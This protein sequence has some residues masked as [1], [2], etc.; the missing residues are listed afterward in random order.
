MTGQAADTNVEAEMTARGYDGAADRYNR[1]RSQAAMIALCQPGGITMSSTPLL[2]A[3]FLQSGH[4]SQSE[5]ATLGSGQ[6]AGM[7]TG[8]LLSS[9]LIARFDRRL[10]ALA[11]IAL[12]IVGHLVSI[13]AVESGYFATLAVRA[14]AGLGEGVLTG[15]GIASLA[16]L[17]SPDRAFGLTV[18]GNLLG[19]ALMFAAMPALMALGGYKAVLLTIV[20]YTLVFGTA[21]FFLPPRGL[22][23]PK[24]A[25]AAPVDVRALLRGC[26]GLA[27]ML[28]L[29]CGV[30]TIWP[31]TPLIGTSYG[32][33]GSSI[34]AAL[35]AAG[36]GGLV[37][38]LFASWLGLR[39]GR[40][41]PILTGGA[42]MILTVFL[43]LN[44]LGPAFFTAEV[45]LFM[46][47][48]IFSVPFYM[49]AFA[50]MDVSGRLAVLSTAMQSLG[51]SA[52]QALGAWIIGAALG[53]VVAA[54]LAMVLFAAA[55]I[56][57]TVLIRAHR[58]S[59][60]AEEPSA[61][62]QAA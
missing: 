26:L 17:R 44:P 31:L 11:A 60:A 49:A 27:V 12:A 36:I 37:A 57:M 28:L 54:W 19:S 2:L 24:P 52:G 3:A 40:V 55:A 25:S 7:T 46:V 33:S 23:V 38:A 16:G 22:A 1:P 42:G 20:G 30:G 29:F 8:Y 58:R 6:L 59:K 48:W 56:L 62:L 32:I 9:L 51:M 47:F 35:S 4:F 15:V 53:H 41:A 39:F 18:S 14:F 10:I 21:V 5:A 43:L 13:E 34:A 50:E 45:I 61:R